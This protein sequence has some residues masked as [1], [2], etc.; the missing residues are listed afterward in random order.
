MKLSIIIPSYN[1]APTLPKIVKKILSLKLSGSNIEVIVVNDGSKDNTGQVLKEF[2]KDKRVKVIVNQKNL[3]KG[4][5]VLK[6]LKIAKGDIILIQDADL[7]YD[8][9]DIPRLLAPFKD[10]NIQ[11]VYGSRVLNKNPISH[12]TFNLGGKL[13]TQLTNFLF[14]T[15][16]TDEPTGYKIF[17]VKLLKGLKLK[18]RRFEFC[19]E[20]TAKIAKRKIKIVEVPINYK[21]R[22]VSEKKIKWYDG[23]A[24][25]YYL[26]KYRFFD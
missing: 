14:D 15:K 12:W 11:V 16:I 8:P 5:S 18:A 6:A 9:V 3:G 19:A 2:L 7:E 1:E 4:A 13:I 22:P 10:K 21:P 24:T 25:I 17:R 23:L 20:V 26:F